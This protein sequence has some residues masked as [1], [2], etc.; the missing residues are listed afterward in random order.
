[1]APNSLDTRQPLFV[2]LLILYWRELVI[3]TMA[4]SSVVKHFNVIKYIT[5]RF[6]VSFVDMTSNTLALK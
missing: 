1:M 2:L 4:P 6:F 5:A 3:E